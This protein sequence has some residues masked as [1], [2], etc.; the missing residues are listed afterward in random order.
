MVSGRTQGKEKTPGAKLQRWVD[1]VAALLVRHYPV[2]FAQLAREVPEY[3][4]E[5][6]AIE[7]LPEGAARDTRFESLKRSF[8][9]DKD[10]L[11][12]FGVPITAAP[13]EDGNDGG[14]Y[15]LE[16]R[17][18]YLPYLC[19]AVPEGTTRRP[20]KVDA[21]GYHALASLTFEA[22]ELQ[23]VVDAA[24]RVRTLGDPMLAFEAEGAMRKLA[25]D[26]PVDAM[27][28]SPDEP[29]VVAARER[30][31]AATFVALGDALRRRKRVSFAYHAMSTDRTEARTVEPYGLFFLTGHW[32]LAARDAGRGE[33]RN[34][35]LNR[36]S[37]VE[38]N[39][40]K[41][42]T[43]DFAI[44][45]TFRLRDHAQSRHAWELGDGDAITAEVEFTGTSGP[46][47]AAMKLGA[48]V[49]GAPDRRAFTVRRID[50]FARWL[51]SFGGELQP[52]SPVAVVERFRAVARDTQ[53]LY[54][55]DA[56][57]TLPDTA[58]SPATRQAPASQSWNAKGASAELR[59]ILLLIPQLAN[60]EERDAEE[61]ARRVGTTVDV[62]QRDLFSLVTRFD[63]PAGWVDGVSVFFE[64]DRVSARSNHF[65][66][67][68]RLTVPELCALELG[69][70]VLRTQ[71]PP[72][73]CAAL[74]RA[75][76]RLRAVIGKLPADAIPDGLYGASMGEIGNT[77]HLAALRRAL[78][79]QRTLHLVYRR[80]GS[81]TPGARAIHPYSLMQAKG[82]L[83]VL[84]Y[85]EQSKE[86][87]VF[88]MDRIESAS[89]GDEAFE[90]PSV[91][92]VDGVLHQGKVLRHDGAD[93]MRVRYSPH[94]ARWIAE[95]EGRQL[96]ADGSLVIDHP[97]A[98]EEWGVRHVLQ[99]GADAEVLAPERMR[100]RIRERLASLAG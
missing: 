59:R 46:T 45:P 89:V 24:A 12:K 74:D 52:V 64:N 20:R 49:A 67:P 60:G 61:V 90:R 71:R 26:L 72:D 3:A 16:R 22:D 4:R 31:D 14:A 7:R 18:F 6:A 8:E 11:K 66:R 27:P 28:P 75:R 57:A 65:L 9:R 63:V 91:I 51:L 99:Y 86:I 100:T 29:R 93:T 95:R 68:M 19:F 53:R 25:V 79:D 56:P 38:V 39:A 48:E 87:R 88:R 73:E 70:A 54:A 35:R 32:Y 96:A 80:S 81:E 13:D 92:D 37:Q 50:S 5:F 94:I 1:L 69:L 62:L 36:M 83:Y 85:C 21:W 34:F 78:R 2:T 55:D 43:P 23:A 15:R 97:L 42:Q 44:P 30:P 33:L 76:D 84:A 10:E 47:I 41:P 58:P 98:D 82:M 77:E 17:D 40:A